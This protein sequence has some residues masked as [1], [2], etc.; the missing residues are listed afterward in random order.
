MQY[1]IVGACVQGHNNVACALITAG[2]SLHSNHHAFPGSANYAI[3][4]GELDPGW[5]VLKAM[6]SLGLVWDL[7]TPDDL[8]YRSELRKH[9]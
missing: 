3:G 7:K 6:A 2:E 5:W 4:P 1:E 9:S 8:P